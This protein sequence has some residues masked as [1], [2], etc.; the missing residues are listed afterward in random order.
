MSKRL[1]LALLLVLSLL[2]LSMVACDR[3]G[4]EAADTASSSA[5]ETP[6][7]RAVRTVTSSRDALSATRTASVSIEPRQESQVAAGTGGRVEAILKREGEL[8]ESGEPVIRLDAD[9]L[10][11]QVQ[12][13]EFRLQSARISLEQAERSSGETGQQAQAQLVTAQTNFD[14]A[15]RQ[16][17]EAQALF[18]AGGVSA[19]ELRNLEAARSQARSSLV[20]ARDA[21]ARSER[22]GTE[23]LALLEVQVQQ[24][25]TALAQARESLGETQITAPFAGEIAE[26]LTEEGEF[27]AA[28]SPAFRLV[29]TERQLGEFSV[30]PQDARALANQGEVSF[31]YQ[32]LDYA[33]QII[34]TSRAANSQRL[35]DMTAELYDSETPIPAGSVAQLRYTVTLGEGVK[36]PSSAIG[37][38]QGGNFVFVVEDNTARRQDVSIVA[39]AGGEAIIEGLETGLQ[40]VS[41]VPADLRN[42]TSVR[43]L[44]ASAQN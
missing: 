39:E 33:A 35:V 6:A 11:L 24:A 14:I 42:G 16:Y 27:V 4:G 44:G 10:S 3:E 7:G 31:R 28:G 9:A 13:A 15:D 43:V 25:E 8:V 23:D 38:E 41:P 30:P 12:D 18:E 32:G 21:V 36:V 1:N 34:R 2:I 22:V 5:A 29:S 37:V 17:Q 26:V 20:Q 40:V 19:T